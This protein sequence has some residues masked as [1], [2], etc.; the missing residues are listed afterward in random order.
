META[1]KRKIV[2]D[3]RLNYPKQM[4]CAENLQLK[5]RLVLFS[6]QI[7]FLSCGNRTPSCERTSSIILM[8]STKDNRL[9]NE[10]KIIRFLPRLSAWLIVSLSTFPALS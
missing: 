3:R 7:Y 9:S 10:R 2:R 5:V 1:V 8:T 4:L 6:A